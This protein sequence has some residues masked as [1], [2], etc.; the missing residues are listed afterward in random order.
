M[1]RFIS[2]RVSENKYL[3]SAKVPY[4]IKTKI[5]FGFPDN[6]FGWLKAPL[7]ELNTLRSSFAHRVKTW[8]SRIIIACKE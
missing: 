3:S 8:N 6:N 1:T 7:E 2:S 4:H 5:F